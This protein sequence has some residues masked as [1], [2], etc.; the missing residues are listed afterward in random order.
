MYT[1]TFRLCFSNRQMAE[2]LCDF[3]LS[4]P[5]LRPY[6]GPAYELLAI[7]AA[8]ALPLNVGGPLTVP[9]LHAFALDWQD[10]PYSLDGWGV[11]RLRM[12]RSQ[13]PFSTGSVHRPNTAEHEAIE[14]MLSYLPPPGQQTVLLLPTVTA[15]AR[16]VL[17]TLAQE[18]P[19]IGQ[20]LTAVTGDGITVNTLFRDRDVAWPP[21]TIPIPLV[22]FTHA[23]PFAWDKEASNP[24]PLGYELPPPLPGEVRSTTEDIEHFRVA[25]EMIL[26][27]AYAGD[28]PTLSRDPAEWTDQ[29]HCRTPP[30]FD[31]TG[32]RSTGSGEYIVVLWPAT[33]LPAADSAQS[34]DGFLD[35]YTRRD[36]EWYRLHR[37]PLEHPRHL[38]N[39]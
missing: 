22:L 21:R 13:I 5:R 30:L 26:A 8:A 24:P 34:Y 25:M 39:P 17:R 10:D 33:A 37:R 9:T 28:P 32:N 23:D 11:P 16:R 36:G 14:H 1:P 4:H 35:V 29:L 27:A 3:I 20:R 15:P 7:G 31:Q 18:D 12:V 19:G 2:A 6:A 38:T